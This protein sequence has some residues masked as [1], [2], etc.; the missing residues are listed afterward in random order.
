MI[1][2]A[3]WLSVAALAALAAVVLPWSAERMPAGAPPAAPPARASVV[4]AAKYPSLQAALDAVPEGGGIVRLPPGRFELHKPLVLTRG[5]TRIEGCGAAT[6]LVNLNTSGA[7]ALVIHSANYPKNPRARIWRVQVADFRISGNPKSGDGLRA[8]GVNEIYVHGLSVD[9][10]GAH[11]VN[12]IACYEDPRVSDAI[13]TY[14]AQ[15]GLNIVGGHNIVVN[16]QFEENQD[17]V[18]CIDSFNLCMNGNNLDDHL[19][20][21]V[22]IE[23]TYGSVVSGNMIE[24][25]GGTAVVMDRDCYGNTVSANVLAHNGGGVD[26]IDAWG[27]AISANTFTMSKTIGVAVRAGSGRIT[28]TGNN[29]SN[30]HIGGKEKR[31]DAAEG[32]LLAGAGDVVVSG[33]IF[34]GMQRGGVQADAACTRIAVTGN[35]L[36]DLNRS[37][38]A[39]PAR[40]IDLAGAKDSLASHNLTGPPAPGKPPR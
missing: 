4:D 11:G 6:H 39:A 29:F 31:Q 36:S 24:E 35:V 18:R 5:Q 22:V 38:P 37:R 28:I 27:C 26:L 12:L 10:H 40:P 7:P 25:C 3:R 1:R 33:N 34:T 20:H 14:N 16:D 30:A 21:G 17:A 13:I 8:E 2:A 32:V 19:R 23:N 9:H 15:A